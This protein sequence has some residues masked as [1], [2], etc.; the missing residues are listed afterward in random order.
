MSSKLF[1]IENGSVVSVTP[2]IHKDM[3]VSDSVHVANYWQNGGTIANIFVTRDGAVQ[4]LMGSTDDLPKSILLPTFSVLDDMCSEQT[5]DSCGQA[6]MIKDLLLRSGFATVH[7]VSKL[8]SVI[9]QN[10]LKKILFVLI[11]G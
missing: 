4:M 2:V 9:E 1:V 7:T 5:Y 10:I 11:G 8:V 6:F 3:F